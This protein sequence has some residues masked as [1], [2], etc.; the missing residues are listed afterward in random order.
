[1]KAGGVDDWTNRID[2]PALSGGK[3]ITS[4]VFNFYNTTANSTTLKWK[5]YSSPTGVLPNNLAGATYLGE[6]SWSRVA[7]GAKSIT[8]T[9]SMRN[10]IA[11]YTGAWYL[12]IK[13]TGE[14]TTNYTGGT[15]T[16]CP[17]FTGVHVDY[18]ACT[19]PTSVSVSPI[20]VPPNNWAMIEFSG[21]EAGTSNAIKEYEIFWSSTPG[22]SYASLGKE[23]G[24]P[25][26][27]PTGVT[28]NADYYY[29][30]K[31]I[32]M[33]AG[34]DS[35]L[36]PASNKLRVE[37]TNPTVKNVK[38]NTSVNNLYV[39][40]GTNVS[41]SWEGENGTNNPITSYT[42]LQN[43]AAYKTGQTSPI[44]VP[45]HANS[46]SSYYY[47][48]IAVAPSGN[49]AGVNSP[50]VYSYDNCSAP[51][52]VSVASNNVAPNTD[53]TLSWSGAGG[54]GTY[55]P[56]TNYDIWR[57]TSPTSGYT[58][59]KTV[60]GTLTSGSTPVGSHA[61]NGSTYYYKVATSGSR[62]GSAQ[63]TVYATLKT[64]WT[65]PTVTGLAV[66]PN[67]V[68]SGGGSTLTWTGN[69][70]TNNA[71]KS[72]T[73]KLGATVIA[74]D[75]TSPTCPV[76]GHATAGSNNVYSV[77]A[78]GTHE[79]GDSTNAPAIYTYS[80]PTAPTSISYTGGTAS[81]TVDAGET[82]ALIWSLAKNGSY[83]N[84]KAYHVYYGDTA[85]QAYPHAGYVG[86]VVT[87]ALNATIDVVANSTMGAA[88]YFFIYPIG[89]K[90]NGAPSVSGAL[91][92]RTYVKCNAPTKPTLGSNNVG[93]EDA[94]AL[95]W[96]GA[97][98]GTNTTIKEYEIWYCATAGGTYTKWGTKSASPMNVTS[99]SANNGTYF[100]KV[101]AVA[102]QAGY[103]S[104]FSPASDA[105]TTKFTAATVT[106]V[107]L[108]GVLTNSYAVKD[109][110]ILLEWTGAG[111]TNNNISSYT[112]LRNGV[113]YKTLVSSSA[114]SYSVVTH[115][116]SG[117][118]YYY[119]VQAIAPNGNSAA[120]NS[121]TVYSY[122]ACAAPTAVNV[123]SNNV[124]P[125]TDI[126]L[127]WSGAATGGIYNAIKNYE[128]WRSLSPTSGY[129]KLQDVTG[130]TAS[131]SL[132]VKKSRG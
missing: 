108:G 40:K 84:I 66:S 7:A 14:T 123:A 36:S 120:V 124:R 53:I 67:Y 30:V 110:S 22:G 68:L 27:T 77:I 34:Y 56:I 33:V 58:L 2:F 79:D 83:N 48:V 47:T 115:D 46:G 4:L 60:A 42:V 28:N 52:A 117:S 85:G 99:P 122:E 10:V 11:G 29:K 43:G 104:D 96:A 35:E 57:S 127:S 128:V 74:S 103:D 12:Y 39:Y 90:G 70:G 41:L 98:G 19:P 105:L 69:N 93:P 118:S 114:S 113:A 44:S 119:S 13:A 121:P 109:T 94:V 25:C 112:I 101:K 89:D 8:F 54:G 18:T 126:L 45:S 21:E 75:L 130:T 76:T 15:S 17:S 26:L 62:T 129:S 78:I 32:G 132:L 16:N 31:T 49:S 38:L 64:Y 23:S 65:K 111:G 72:Y 37:Y 106:G 20:S 88:R 61:G 59:L 82:I 131:G 95:T 73:V 50:T 102:N 5:F 97:S 71:I 87:T 81:K 107:K 116:A 92:A 63:S 3:P 1:M 51:T 9:E 86:E 100:Y 24:S 55:N 6:L 80:Q 91:T 125:N